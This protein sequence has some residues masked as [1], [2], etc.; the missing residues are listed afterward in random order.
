MAKRNLQ[1]HPIHLGKSASA[2]AQPEFPQDER[3]MQWYMDYGARHAGD[4]A[5]GRLVA[6]YDFTG[7]WP[8]WE[9]HP[10]GEEVVVC[11]S[12]SIELVQEMED[13]SHVSTTLAPGEYAINPKGVW[14]TANVSDKARV[15][16]ITPGMGTENR[17]R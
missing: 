2:T 5:E 9:V 3:A 6:L 15:L 10:H 4:G 16:F 8:S 7:D 13:G 11:V 14:H 1:T 17:P 12:G